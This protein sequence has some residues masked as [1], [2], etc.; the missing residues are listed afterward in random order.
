M[1]NFTMRYIFLLFCLHHFVLS[2]EY[3]LQ[4]PQV[5]GGQVNS[6]SDSYNLSSNTATQ[7]A[8][9]SSSDSLSFSP[10]IMGA[11]YSKKGANNFKTMSPIIISPPNF[12]T[13]KAYFLN[14]YSHELVQF[15]VN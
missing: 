8:D 11:M 4:S 6:S 1:S 3:I 10:G 7:S 15:H 2:Q 13:D 5:T 9:A 12:L 14:Y